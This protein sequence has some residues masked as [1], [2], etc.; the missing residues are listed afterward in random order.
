VNDVLEGDV[1]MSRVKTEELP[2][3]MQKM[4]VAERKAYIE[5]QKARRDR[6]NL[7]LAE[8]SQTRK[9]SKETA[10]NSMLTGIWELSRGNERE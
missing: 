10:G 7:R 9:G 2:A 4:S 8:L 5:K 1:D 6:L 3:E